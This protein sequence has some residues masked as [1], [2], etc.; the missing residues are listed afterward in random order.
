MCSFTV[1]ITWIDLRISNVICIA[2]SKHGSAVK[3]NENMKVAYEATG[4]DMSET[5]TKN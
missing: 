5:G 1:A 4:I 2:V 3:N